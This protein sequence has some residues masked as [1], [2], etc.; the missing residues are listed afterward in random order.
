MVHQRGFLPL[1]CFA[2][3]LWWE[4]TKHERLG[5]LEDFNYWHQQHH[6]TEGLPLKTNKLVWQMSKD[7]ELNHWLPIPHPPFSLPIQ[8]FILLK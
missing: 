8:L 6:V 5:R 2:F 3:F 4:A 1:L 7:K